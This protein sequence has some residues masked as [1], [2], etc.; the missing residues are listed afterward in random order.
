MTEHD[1]RLDGAADSDLTE[2]E[3][4]PCYKVWTIYRDA[5]TDDLNHIVPDITDF[6]TGFKAGWAAVF[7]M[8]A[9]EQKKLLQG[10]AYRKEK[11]DE[12]IR[13]IVEAIDA[14]PTGKKLYY[15]VLTGGVVH[16]YNF[17]NLTTDDL[18][19]LTAR[20]RAE[21]DAAVEALKRI[22]PASHYILDIIKKE[23]FVFDGSGGR[24]EKLA[25]TIYADLVSASTEARM[26]LEGEEKG[27]EI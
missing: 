10:F 18:K 26:V 25:M 22:E 16:G 9:D 23:N 1:W 5:Q 21:R 7:R 19:Y 2:A 6:R 4:T 12:M 15:A 24:W 20:L 8:L 13:K 14:A 17:T 11:G 27:D 3:R